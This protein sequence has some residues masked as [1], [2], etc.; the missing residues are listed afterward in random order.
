MQDYFD[1]SWTLTEILFSSLISDSAFYVPPKHNLRHPMIFYYG[2]PAALYINKLRVAGLLHEPIN[3]YFETIFETGV[4]EMSW[5]DLSKNS[6]AWPS[7]AEVQEYR[8]EVYRVVSG[9]I[10][11][12]KKEQLQNID[13]NSPLWSLAMSFEHERIHLETSS[14]LINELPLK[15]LRHPKHLPP[16]HNSIPAQDVYEPQAG[17]HY[18]HNSM[19]DTAACRV[20]LGKPLDFPG[21]GWDNEYG[22]REYD[23]PAFRASKYKVSNGEF[24]EFVKSGGYGTREHWSDAGWAWRSYRNVKWPTFWQSVG[25]QGL[26]HFRLRLMFDEVPMPWDWPVTVNLHEAEAFCSWRN[27][28]VAEGSVGGHWRYRLLSELEYKAL[29]DVAITSSGVRDPVLHS[30]NGRLSES[31]RNTSSISASPTQYMC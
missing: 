22:K 31:V 25:P 14:V 6:M 18:P 17:V 15:Y 7:V 23:L 24:L 3:A 16:Y 5:D 21:F 26:H 13:K 29:L 27:A 2:H 10:Q 12:L 9:L 4:D 30:N 8:R 11:S 28:T 19:I 20:T 1:N